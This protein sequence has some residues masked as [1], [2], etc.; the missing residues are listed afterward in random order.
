[1][2]AA[3]LTRADV[4]ARRREVIE[5]L[6]DAFNERDID[7][8]LSHLAP[9][10][11][12]PNGMTGGRIHGR[13]A[14]R[15]YWL[16]RWRDADPVVKPMRIDFAADDTVRVRVDQLVRDLAGKILQNGQVEHVYTFDGAFIVRMMIVDAEPDDEDE[17]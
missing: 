14:V 1:L 3:G 17:E 15:Q 11:D 7:A 8:A 10:V 16:A 12:W 13:D 6:C 9:G 4:D 5:A 2:T